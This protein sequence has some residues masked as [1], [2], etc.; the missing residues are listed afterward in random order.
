MDKN[1]SYAQ[2]DLPIAKRSRAAVIVG[3]LCAFAV[4]GFFLYAA[5]GKITN[6]KQF[7]VDIGIFKMAFMDERYVNI[8]AIL[9]PWIEVSAAIAL[10]FPATRKGG[11]LLI[12][13]LL[14]FFIY[15]VYDAAIVRGLDIV[16]GCTGK[17]SGKAGWLTIGRNTLLLGATI[18]SVFLT[19][20]RTSS[21]PAE[22]P[23]SAASAT[24]V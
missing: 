1:P 6:V 18:A 19:R 10:L 8:P 11:A 24:A 4:A 9:L 23:T 16:C 14:L 13:G 20:N 3:H 21:S 5:F 17:D 2:L 22:I 7:A 12:G 15:A